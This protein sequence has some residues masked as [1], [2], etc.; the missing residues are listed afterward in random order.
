[1]TKKRHVSS[2]DMEPAGTMSKKGESMTD[3]PHLLARGIL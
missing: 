3:Q 1:M 2:M